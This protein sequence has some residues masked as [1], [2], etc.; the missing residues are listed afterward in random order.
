[1]YPVS[2]EFLAALESSH[3]M[4]TRVDIYVDNVLR[5]GNLPLS[6]GNVKMDDT[7]FRT[8]I[9]LT[10]NDAEAEFV[11]TKSLDNVLEVGRSV[12]KAYRGLY[13]PGQT[14]PTMVPL[15]CAIVGEVRVDDSGQ[16][17]TIGVRGNDYA[18]K[19]SAQ[20]L[21]WN[22]SIPKTMTAETAIRNLVVWQ[23][24]PW[25]D[26]IFL[27]DSSATTAGRVAQIGEDPW[28]HAQS[29]A[30][31]IGCDLYFDESL[32][33]ICAE[34]PDVGVVVDEYVEGPK[35]RLLY[36]SKIRSLEGIF[37]RVVVS[38]D[39]TGNTT[40]VYGNAEDRNPTS[41]TNIDRIGRRTHFT[42][43]S[44]VRTS[45]QAAAMARSLLKK[46]S[47]RPE[48][49]ELNT[50][51]NPALRLGDTILVKRAKLGMDSKQVVDKVTFPLTAKRA[52]SMSTRER[53]V[54]S[55]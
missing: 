48:R 1:M 17:L 46:K 23:L 20:K 5:Y 44:A 11:P 53:L 37:N 3:R 34:T 24:E 15:G 22:L 2:A 14:T 50:V 8:Q 28:T 42:S 31:G 39:A 7:V 32:N 47:G 9:D 4:S 19:I 55:A 36:G 27:G 33:L 12:I 49:V 6:D 54:D 43:S 25:Q 45:S 38:S 13:L 41:P 51:V 35:C 52:C 18:E 10:I 29:I 21:D 16:G 26:F 40:T 30:R